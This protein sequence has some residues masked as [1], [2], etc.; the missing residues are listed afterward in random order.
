[1][2]SLEKTIK[3]QH[4]K[5]LSDENIQNPNV[6]LPSFFFFGFQVM[7]IRARN[8]CLLCVSSI[9]VLTTI[10]YIFSWKFKTSPFLTETNNPK[11]PNTIHFALLYDENDA[12][13][14]NNTIGI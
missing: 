5:N 7:K 3:Q 14:R 10:G 13:K 9:I 4:R 8:F 6:N 1:M 11:V 2:L 12:S